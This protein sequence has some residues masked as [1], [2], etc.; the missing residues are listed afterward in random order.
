MIER[1]RLQTAAD[2]TG[3]RR[4]T[5]GNGV[6]R[7]EQEVGVCERDYVFM[8]LRVN[9]DPYPLCVSSVHGVCALLLSTVQYTKS[10]AI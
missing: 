7:I 8:C 3:G 9:W 6:G 5:G 10:M 1:I 2:D 4:G